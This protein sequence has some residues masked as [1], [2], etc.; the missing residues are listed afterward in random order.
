MAFVEEFR[1]WPRIGT[2][3]RRVLPALPVDR[4]KPTRPLRTA[5][6]GLTSSTRSSSGGTGRILANTRVCRLPCDHLANLRSSTSR[7]KSR[8]RRG[9]IRRRG[10]VSRLL[11]SRVPGPDRPPARWG[12]LRTGWIIRVRR[13]LRTFVRRSPPSGVVT[14]SR[15]AASPRRTTSHTF[16]DAAVWSP[17]MSTSS[18]ASPHSEHRDH[19]LLRALDARETGARGEGVPQRRPAKVV[20][21]TRGVNSSAWRRWSRF[22][23]H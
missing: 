13:A 17:P 1:P 16:R 19:A 7:S 5:S 9:P 4:H 21:A 15:H 20:T 3:P 14:P 10:P 8:R 18:V 22:L 6:T 12:I 11:T 23:P 2:E